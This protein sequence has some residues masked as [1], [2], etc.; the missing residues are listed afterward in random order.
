MYWSTHVGSTDDMA[1]IAVLVGEGGGGRGS[2]ND[3]CEFHM[4]KDKELGIK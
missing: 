4:P 2:G 1:G 3:A